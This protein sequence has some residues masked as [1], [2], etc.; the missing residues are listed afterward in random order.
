M[1]FDPGE[2]AMG[3]FSNSKIAAAPRYLRIF[4]K[5]IAQTKDV[6]TVVN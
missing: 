4:T 2:N 5:L 3:E 1:M 6:S